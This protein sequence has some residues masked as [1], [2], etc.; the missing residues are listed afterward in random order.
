MN[1]VGG[2][3]DLVGFTDQVSKIQE[4]NMNFEYKYQVG[5]KTRQK[6]MILLSTLLFNKALEIIE[7]R[8]K[9]GII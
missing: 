1:N 2:R 4:F 8:Q 3:Y 6:N 7:L 5:L 9:E